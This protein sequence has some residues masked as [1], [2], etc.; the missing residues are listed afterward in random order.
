MIGAGLFLS[1]LFLG[2]AIRTFEQPYEG[3][4]VSSLDFKYMTNAMWLII[5]TM[6]TV[7]Y[8]D[9][10][11]STHCGRIIATVA[12]IIGMLLISLMVVSLTVSSEFSKEEAKAYYILKRL[13]ADDAVKE[14]AA[15]VIKAAFRL[16]NVRDHRKKKEASNTLMLRFIW[17]TKMKKSITIFKN[18]NKVAN[19]YE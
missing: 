13:Y 19:N 16:A 11:P 5:I 6:T 9:G 10:Y 18:D 3:D 7:G 4:Q 1:I 15:D 8:G 14:K 2:A 17:F 12:C